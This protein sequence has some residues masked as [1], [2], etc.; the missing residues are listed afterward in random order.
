MDGTMGSTESTLHSLYK[1]DMLHP[2]QI[3]TYFIRVTSKYKLRDRI[4]ST[5]QTYAHIRSHDRLK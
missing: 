3:D 2:K 4:E 5:K 1:I